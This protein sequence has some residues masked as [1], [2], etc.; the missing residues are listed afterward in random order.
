MFE[1]HV[2]EKVL[3][4]SCYLVVSVIWNITAFLFGCQ[5]CPCAEENL[6][7]SSSFSDFCFH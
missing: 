3:N 5:S 6:L 2:P 4:L 1:L 7:A